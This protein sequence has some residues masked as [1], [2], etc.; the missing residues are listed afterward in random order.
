MVR[1]LR[2]VEHVAHE[3]VDEYWSRLY[4]MPARTTKGVLAKLRLEGQFTD[5]QTNVPLVAAAMRDL[6]V[7]AGAAA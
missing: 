2:A 7:M 4:D 1:R 3:A 5:L 6:E